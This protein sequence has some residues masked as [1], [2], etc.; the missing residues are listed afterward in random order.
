MKRVLL[1]NKTQRRIKCI[2]FLL[3]RITLDSGIFFFFQERGRENELIC[4]SLYRKER[5]KEK[6]KEGKEWK[7]KEEKEEE[8]K[9]RWY[10]IKLLIGKNEQKDFLFV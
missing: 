7:K 8:K 1:G 5:E 3:I 6:E 10:C 4:T 9:R 2:I